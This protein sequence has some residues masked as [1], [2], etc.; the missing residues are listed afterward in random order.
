MRAFVTLL[1]LSLFSRLVDAANH[2]FKLA[3]RSNLS[4]SDLGGCTNTKYFPGNIFSGG[5]WSYDYVDCSSYDAYDNIIQIYA[6]P[7]PLNWNFT[8]SS[9]SIQNTGS[10]ASFDYSVVNT[11][12]SPITQC[13]G[14]LAPGQSTSCSALT[15]PGVVGVSYQDS[16]TMDINIHNKAWTCGAQGTVQVSQT[17]VSGS[18]AGV[19]LC[20]GGEFYGYLAGNS[21]N[22]NLL[23][24]VTG[25]CVLNQNPAIG[26]PSVSCDGGNAYCCPNGAVP[27][28][29]NIC[30]SG[31]GS[32]DSPCFDCTGRC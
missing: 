28:A 4:G 9:I 10:C 19:D 21:A 24:Y 22:T 8:L 13:Q 25:G 16:I 7:R 6:S 11:F 15:S 2:S 14:T 26:M 23:T 20:S 5:Y 17:C 3:P 30:G 27:S 1:I 18:P 31:D 12:I 29:V 32:N